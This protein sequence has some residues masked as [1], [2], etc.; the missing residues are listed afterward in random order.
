M[1][2][3]FTNILLPNQIKCTKTGCLCTK[4]RV[5][6]VGV[7]SVPRNRTGYCTA[8]AITCVRRPW[9]ARAAAVERAC[10]G[11]RTTAIIL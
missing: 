11:R 6:A 9:Y 2:G 10:H 8:A 3:K 7:S 4:D 1:T 5:C